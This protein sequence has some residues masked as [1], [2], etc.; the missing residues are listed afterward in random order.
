MAANRSRSDRNIQS[1]L[2]SRILSQ[3]DIIMALG[4]IWIVSTMV[5]PIPS[6]MLDLLLSFS[7]TFSLI[8]LL[9]TLYT[10]EPLQFSVFPGLLLILTLFRLSLNVASTRLILLHADAGKV[11]QAFGTFVVGGNYVVGLVI[12]LILVIIQFVVITK[13]AG[14][15][16]EVAARFTLDAMPGKQMA[17]DADLNTGIITEEEAKK[18]RENI[19]READFY[20]AMDGASKFVRGDAIAGI[21]ITLI[22]IIGGFIIGIVQMKLTFGEALRTYTLLTVGDGLVT[23]IPALIVSSAAGIIVSRAA[24]ES[25]LGVDLSHQILHHPRA[26]YIASI[27]LM[28][29]GIMPGLPSAPFFILSVIAGFV[30]Y[31]S[32]QLQVKEQEI[33]PDQEAGDE[34]GGERLEDLLH[35]DPLELEIGYG[36]I[37]LVDVEQ[38]GDLL[39]RITLIRRQCAIELGIVIPLVRIRDN[40]QLRPMEYN[41]KIKGIKISSGDVVLNHFLALNS[42]LSREKIEGIETKEPVF[43]LPA[44]WIT[45]RD[46]DEAETKGY[47]V[48]EVPAVIA[49][50]LTEVIRNHACELLG[51]QEVKGLVDNIRKDYPAV[52]EDLIPNQLSIGVIQKILQNL[53]RERVSIRDLVTILEVAGEMIGVT[54]DLDQITEYI[55]QA[56]GRSI[57]RSYVNDDGVLEVITIE[58]NL[59]AQLTGSVKDTGTGKRIILEPQTAQGVIQTI[60][61]EVQRVIKE[62]NQPVILCAPSIRLYLKR[63]LDSLIPGIAVL[64]YNEVDHTVE[65]KSIGMVKM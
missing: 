22:N 29:F 19:S 32:R 16:A 49:T 33:P 24:S 46:K 15:I 59:E 18:R 43:G 41:I 60:T 48:I 45:E 27:M 8:V 61:E 37:P 35:V 63:M 7:I 10:T 44:V 26:L 17:I 11:I 56:L 4:V 42:G 1:T 5:I 62:N 14:R 39:E 28:F 6:G 12:F 51:K 21:I 34:D 23:Q 53:L 3:A 13:G 40:I 65:V 47:T 9:V 55:R 2:L 64:A 38:K 57:T 54:Q 50:H 52:V 20:G 30:G 25:N 58:P 31:A 36:L